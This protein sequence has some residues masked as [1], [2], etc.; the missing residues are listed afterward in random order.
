MKRQ[1]IDALLNLE[2][3]LWEI[4]LRLE[5]L[6]DSLIIYLAASIQFGWKDGAS[7]QAVSHFLISE[8]HPFITETM[9]GIRDCQ[10][11]AREIAHDMKRADSEN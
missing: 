1:Q 3:F 9:A 10:G 5:R 7:L 6:W 4:L 11:I 8:M 2:L